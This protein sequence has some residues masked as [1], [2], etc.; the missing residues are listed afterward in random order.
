LSIGQRQQDL[1]SR[2]DRLRSGLQA[3]AHGEAILACD[4]FTVDT[5]FFKRLYVLF[6]LELASRRIVFRCAARKLGQEF[7]VHYHQA[8]AH[9]RDLTSDCPAPAP[10]AG[11]LSQA[12]GVVRHIAP[13]PLFR[14]RGR[15]SGC[16]LKDV[17]VELGAQGPASDAESPFCTSL[18][19][20]SNVMS[21]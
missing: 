9:I 1:G 17:E 8:Y 14:A 6:F 11:P 13:R 19:T 10:H 18:T 5:V 7:L 21:K 12:N 15:T 2:R 16:S 20:A 4:Y 3:R